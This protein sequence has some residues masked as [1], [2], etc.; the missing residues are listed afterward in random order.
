MCPITLVCNR[1]ECNPIQW[2][3]H[4]AREVQRF[5]SQLCAASA[6]LTMR[7]GEDCSLCTNKSVL[8]YC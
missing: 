6:V 1:E 7:L 2:V 8:K 3:L 4:Y 5:G